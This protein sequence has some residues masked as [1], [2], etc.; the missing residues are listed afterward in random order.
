MA[1]K[2]LIS[3]QQLA[4]QLA[5]PDW[6][7]LDCRFS[8]ADAE[9]GGRAYRQGHIPGAHYVHLNNDLSAAVTAQT[10]RHPLPDF[11]QLAARLGAWGVGAHSQVV[12]YDDVNGAMAGRLW[13]LLRT[14][15]HSAVALLDGGLQHWQAQGYA[16]TTH[17]PLPHS[18]VLR[19]YVDDRQWL[20]AAQLENGLARDTITLIDARSAER[21]SGQSE[22]IDAVAGHVPKALNRPFQ[23]NLAANGQFLPA[24]T[25][26]Q[27]FGALIG[28][29]QPEQVVH[30]CGSGVTACHN[31]LAMEIAG[32]SGSKLYAGSWS[33]WI[34]NRNR[35]VA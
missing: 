4:A 25:L 8:L 27:A 21:F 17:L 7:V 10:G 31:L 2:T 28:Q 6:V 22:P 32:L 30:M 20:T 23:D 26:R 15:G 18:R 33:E 34:V 14:L 12:V 3:A 16:M 1:F 35:A 11:R 24:A 29:R 13:W 9:A 19:A 5:Q